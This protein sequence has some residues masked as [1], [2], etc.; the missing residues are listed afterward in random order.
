[1]NHNQ[2]KWLEPKLVQEITNR[3]GLCLKFE[4]PGN[5]GVQ[6]RLIFMPGGRLYIVELKSQ[7]K[8]LRKL[9]EWWQRRFQGLGF[10]AR[11]VDSEEELNKLLKYI[12]NEGI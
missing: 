7:G 11:K 10:N 2:E 3:N 5:R 12:D 4:S 1:M 8:E 6:D 9:Q